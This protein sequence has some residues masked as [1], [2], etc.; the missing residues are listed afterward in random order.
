M[1]GVTFT[2]KSLAVVITLKKGTA[3]NQFRFEN[4]AM[5]V[6]I[7]KMG[8]TEFAKANLQIFGLSIETMAQLTTLSFNPFM[9]DWNYIEILAGEEGQ[10]LQSIFKGE[11]TL[12]YADLNG[13]SKVLKIQAQTG[14]YPVLI[15]DPPKSVEGQQTAAS[16]IESLAKQSNYSFENEGVTATISDCTISGDPVTKMR[17]IAQMVGAD[18]LIDD[19]TVVL[20]PKDGARKAEGGIP[21]VAVDTGMIGYPVFTNTG[22]QASTYFRPDLRLGAMVRVESIIPGATGLW[23]IVKLTHTLSV[24]NPNGGAWRTDF[25]AMFSM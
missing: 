10:T 21:V 24:N 13:G 7:E 22:L 14:A 25:E 19:D 11:I 18:L 3:N 9:N 5:S 1:A 8:G 15:A 23:R 17:T 2:R 4:F 16:L 6:S 12:S 20:L